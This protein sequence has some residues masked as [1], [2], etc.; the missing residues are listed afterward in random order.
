MSV[1]FGVTPQRRVP[2]PQPIVKAID[3]DAPLRPKPRYAPWS[4]AEDGV[5]RERGKLG[6]AA[7]HAVIPHRSPDAIRQR[8]QKLGVRIK[9][10]VKPGFKHPSRRGTKPITSRCH[11]LVRTYIEELNRRLMTWEEAEKI[12]GVGVGTLRSWSFESVPRL[13]TFIA[14]LNAVGLDLAIVA[15]EAEA[16]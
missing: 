14:A 16:K 11:P 9:R 13:D 4:I 2:P 6:W 8:A 3:R 7:I 12:T 5:I 10:K 1:A 15:K